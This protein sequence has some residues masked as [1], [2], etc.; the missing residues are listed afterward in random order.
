M[1]RCECHAGASRP[2]C[3]ATEI[4]CNSCKACAACCADNAPSCGAQAKALLNATATFEID[5]ATV[6]RS[7]FELNFKTAISQAVTSSGGVCSSDD[8][9]V[10]RL[11]SGSVVVDYTMHVHSYAVDH[12]LVAFRVVQSEGVSVV[13]EDKPIQ[14]ASMSHVDAT[15]NGAKVSSEPQLCKDSLYRDD[16]GCAAAAASE[17]LAGF[18][19]LTKFDIHSRSCTRS[20]NCMVSDCCTEPQVEDEVEVGEE[21]GLGFGIL[22]VVSYAV[23]LIA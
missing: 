10:N 14:A 4:E 16:A 22:I 9:T 1:D 19:V 8:V 15:I 20:K 11:T 12:T 7:V 17:T 5:I 23:A 18:R 6:N 13:H 3:H 21:D 2:C